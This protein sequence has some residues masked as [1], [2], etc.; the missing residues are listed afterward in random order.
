[1]YKMIVGEISRPRREKWDLKSDNPYSVW[2]GTAYAAE[3]CR[4]SALSSADY[5]LRNR[6][7]VDW[8]SVAW[9]GTATEIRRLFEAER[10]NDTGLHS[11]EEGKDYAVLFLEIALP[12]CA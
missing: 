6:L 11:L 12:I 9:K 7:D 1:M 3:N 2:D 8:G 5:C 10:L 4:I